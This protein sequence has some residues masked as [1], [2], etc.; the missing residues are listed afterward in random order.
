MRPWLLFTALICAALGGAGYHIYLNLLHQAGL[1]GGHPQVTGLP[2]EAR[3]RNLPAW[4]GPHPRDTPRP[5][6]TFEFPIDFGGTG[7]V[8]PLFA[9]PPQ[10]PFVC[11]SEESNLGQ[12]LIDNN[13]GWGMPVYAEDG[14]GRRSDYVIGYSKDCSLPTRLH[15]L[16]YPKGSRKIFPQRVDNDVALAP[17]FN[18][19]LVRVETGTINRYIYAILMPTSHN[20]QMHE[21][22]T[23]LWNGK[24]IYYLRG[25][26]SIGFQQGRVRLDRLVRDMRPALEKGYAVVFSSANETDNTYNIRL[27]EDTAR[28]LKQQFASRY[29]PPLFTLAIGGSGGGLQQYLLGQNAP[30]LIDGG[31]ALIAYPDMITQVHYALD[32][33]LLEYYFDQLSSNRDYWQ[34]PAR[35]EAV[36][37]LSVAGAPHPGKEPRLQ[38]L[39]DTAHVLRY[40]LPDPTPPGSECNA[41]WRGSTPLINNPRFHSD[42][43]RFSRDVR[44]RTFWTHWQDNR[45]VYGTDNLGRAPSPWSNLGVQYGL[46]ALR[47]GRI[48]IDQF[49][50]LNSRIG[51]WKPASA[52]TPEHLWHIS[53][54]SR[55]YRLSPYGEHNM[56]HSGAVMDN[57]PRFRGSLNAARAA[58][59][60]G[61]VFMGKIDIPIMDVRM[62]LD[63]EQN[64][65][66]TWAALSTRQRILNAGG[67]AALNPIWITSKPYNPMWDALWVLD[68]W[69]SNGQQLQARGHQPGPELW[70]LARPEAADDRCFNTDGQVIAHGKGVWDGSWN[71]K[72][73]GTCTSLM[74]FHQSSRQVAGDD[75]Q[76][77]TFQ[78][79]LIPVEQAIRD[80]FYGDRD[81]SSYQDRLKGIFPWGVCDYRQ[82]DLA[83][84]TDI[85]RD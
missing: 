54:D 65:H 4:S 69:V 78:C 67:D 43:F 42:W 15:Y 23:T 53:G 62:Y 76:G 1:D 83:R 6:E 56:T 63:D 37:G 31:V 71:Q 80:D 8:Q 34:D 40:E 75:I 35:R 60:S 10:Y 81:M 17:E 72:E 25:G 58:Y 13:Q 64:I 45:D 16:Y 21:P 85:F 47:D 24:L 46:A 3:R 36:M 22:D 41:G 49:I 5:V 55:L 66:H 32:C 59:R 30:G 26:I 2:P 19:L 50:E 39:H 73:D 9:G 61:N 29:R 44:D 11:Q 7:P 77:Y 38:W 33:E 14:K 51:S 57:A 82:P 27:Q 20:D 68:Q 28:R 12:P 48:G 79:A 74:P 70:H 84:P 18:D 52:M